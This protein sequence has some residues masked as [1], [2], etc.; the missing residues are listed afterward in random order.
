MTD[1]ER[2]E[3][4][5]KK[6]AKLWEIRTYVDNDAQGQRIDGVFFNVEQIMA[7]QRVN[8]IR[9]YEQ[10]QKAVEALKEEKERVK[11]LRDLEISAVRESRE[12]NFKTEEARLGWIKMKTESSK[13]YNSELKVIDNL[14]KEY[15]GKNE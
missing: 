14:I 3:E 7:L 8:A 10:N 15:G 13:I 9:E 11:A 5:E 2:I 1:K 4:L 12:F 6:V